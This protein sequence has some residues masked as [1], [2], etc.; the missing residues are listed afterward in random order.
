MEKTVVVGTMDR[1]KTISV[2]E[3]ATVQEAFSEAGMNIGNH[4]IQTLSGEEV[5]HDEEVESGTTYIKVEK[6][7]G[8]R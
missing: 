3:E 8:G 5:D 4:T 1:L 7:K 2:D 6:M